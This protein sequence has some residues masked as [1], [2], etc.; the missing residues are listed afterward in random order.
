QNFL[1]QRD[2][3]VHGSNRSSLPVC[4]CRE[5]PRHLADDSAV[6]ISQ[7]DD[8]NSVL[9]KVGHIG[10]KTDVVPVMLDHQMAVDMIDMQPTRVVTLERSGHFSQRRSCQYSAAE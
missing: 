4:H 5:C 7:N 6:K 10:V 1:R 2:F 8:R 3:L 9:G